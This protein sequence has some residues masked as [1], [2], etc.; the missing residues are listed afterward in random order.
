MQFGPH[1]GSLRQKHRPAMKILKMLPH[2]SS[3]FGRL[4]KE[5]RWRG[6]ATP[7]ALLL[8]LASC[9]SYLP[10]S[11]VTSKFPCL[12]LPKLPRDALS[13]SIIHCS[14]IFLPS[15]CNFPSTFLS[16]FFFFPT[17]NCQLFPKLLPPLYFWPYV[18]FA[19]VLIRPNQSPGTRLLVSSSTQQMK[20]VRSSEAKGGFAPLCREGERGKRYHVKCFPLSPMQSRF[21]C[22]NCFSI[23]S[24]RREKSRKPF[25]KIYICIYI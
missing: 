14:T 12:F 15:P 1:Q 17:N 21:T 13:R 6:T 7:S 3:I 24:K 5:A 8:P 22:W 25:K 9:S 20:R 18:F 2:I 10:L 19:I 16:F 11:W 23:C 4:C